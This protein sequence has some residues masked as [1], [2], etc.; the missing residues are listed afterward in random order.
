VKSSSQDSRSL[1]RDW[2]RG[3]PECKADVLTAQ[4]Q[5]KVGRKRGKTEKEPRKLYDIRLHFSPTSSTGSSV[6][7][8]LQTLN[9]YRCETHTRAMGVQRAVI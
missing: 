5:T 2:N 3:S 1:G 7:V 4:I 9:T 8:R 6:S